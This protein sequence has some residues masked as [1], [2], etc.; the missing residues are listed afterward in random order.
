MA[1]FAPFALEKVETH[2]GIL[3]LTAVLLRRNL[4]GPLHE[5]PKNHGNYWSGSYRTEGEEFTN[6]YQ[7]NEQGIFS[8][9]KI[10]QKE[11]RKE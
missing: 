2:E 9:P 1:A 3:P 8:M 6:E 5:L 7:L 11:K 4:F 10:Y